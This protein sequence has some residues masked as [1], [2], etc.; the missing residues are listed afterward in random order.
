MFNIFR[1]LFGGILVM[2]ATVLSLIMFFVLKEYDPKM[3]IEQVTALETTILLA[4]KIKNIHISH[5][6]IYKFKKK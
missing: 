1:G 5:L 6:Q 4:G 2:A 3:A